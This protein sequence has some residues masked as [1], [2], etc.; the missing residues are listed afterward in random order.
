MGSILCFGCKDRFDD[1]DVYED[2]RNDI[3]NKCED[4]GEVFLPG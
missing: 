2:H 1:L 3:N 4:K